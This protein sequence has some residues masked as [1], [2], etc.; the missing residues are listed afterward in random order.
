[1]NHAELLHLIRDARWFDLL[2]DTSHGERP[3]DAAIESS[4]WDWLPTTRDQ[5]DPIT[6]HLTC[7]DRNC[8]LDAAKVVLAALR[9]IDE[10]D[11][12]LVAGASD[13]MP[14]AKGGAQYAAVH[15]AR[16]ISHD[17]AGFWC[18]CVRYYARGWWPLGI[19]SDGS[20]VVF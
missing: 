4:D 10:T 16:E 9:S 18:K 6:S 8:E 1:M 17:A 11:R 12:R 13:M 5:P 20:L 15:A 2:G 3:Y 7:V 19:G 14:A